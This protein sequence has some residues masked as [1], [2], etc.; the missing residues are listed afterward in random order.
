MEE[1]ARRG[2]AGDSVYSSSPS[3]IGVTLA[4]PDPVPSRR[5]RTMLTTPSTFYSAPCQGVTERGGR[6]E[7]LPAAEAWWR[8]TESELQRRLARFGPL[9]DGGSAG[10][11]VEAS[12]SLHRLWTMLVRLRLPYWA[13]AAELHHRQEPVPPPRSTVPPP[14]H[15]ARTP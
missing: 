15:T 4:V 13:E 10:V 11:L 9:S 3:V 1:V 2:E 7:V 5:G 6:E 8:L 12:W 14:T